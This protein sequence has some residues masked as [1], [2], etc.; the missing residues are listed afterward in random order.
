MTITSFV[1]VS[2]LALGGLLVLWMVFFEKSDQRKINKKNDRG[3]ERDVEIK[4]VQSLIEKMEKENPELVKK[5]RSQ[6]VA[7]AQLKSAQN[8]DPEDVSRVIKYWLVDE[9][10][11]KN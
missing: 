11:K 9:E 1:V 10:D 4:K 6:F 2:I 7:D 3:T 5:I 8:S